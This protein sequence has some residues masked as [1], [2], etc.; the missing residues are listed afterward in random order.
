MTDDGVVPLGHVANHPPQHHSCL[1]K[2]KQPEAALSAVVSMWQGP[3]GDAVGAPVLL[4]PSL[5]LAQLWAQCLRQGAAG[6]GGHGELLE[7]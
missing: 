1:Q 3:R 6:Q 5:P 4:P 2:T 7:R